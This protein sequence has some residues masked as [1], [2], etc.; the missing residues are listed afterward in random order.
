MITLCAVDA[1]KSK[2]DRFWSHVRKKPLLGLWKG[3]WLLM[4]WGLEQ[5]LTQW[6]WDARSINLCVPFAGE[7]DCLPHAHPRPTDCRHRLNPSFRVR[8]DGLVP[9]LTPDAAS[10]N[11]G[12][13]RHPHILPSHHFLPYL[14]ISFPFLGLSFHHPC[15]SLSPLNFSPGKQTKPVFTSCS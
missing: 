4:T 15:I 9:C 1:L 8:W 14:S 11:R 7:G 13:D 10:K 2:D 12:P 3:G 6:Y 5:A